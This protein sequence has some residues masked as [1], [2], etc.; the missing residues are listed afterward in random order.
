MMTT[1]ISSYERWLLIFRE[2]RGLLSRARH[3]RALD[4]GGQV[5]KGAWGMSWRQKAMKGVEVCDKP[6]GIDK[7]VLIPGFPN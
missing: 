6:G 1:I 3:C 4:I 2:E 7:R 5:I